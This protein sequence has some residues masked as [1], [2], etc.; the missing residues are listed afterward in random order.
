VFNEDTGIKETIFDLIKYAEK[1]DWEVIV[2]NDGSTDNTGKILKKMNRIKVINH[3]YNKGYGA[4]LK[5]GLR[6]ANTEFVAFYDGDGQHSPEDLK[7]LVENFG[8]FDMIVGERIKG[9]HREWIRR[10]GK[11]ILS[12]AANFLSGKK[13]PDLNSGMRVIKR[14]IISKLLHLMPDGFS[15]STTATIAFLNLG[16]N[17]GYYPIQT[18][19]R[20]GKSSV[21]QIKH[22]SNI[23]LLVI[24][25]VVLFNP[26]KIFLPMS[27][28]LFVFGVIYEIL[29]GIIFFSPGV[30]L[31][32][33]AL[34]MLIS[35]VII[36]FFGLVV[37]QIS[38][39]RKYI[40]F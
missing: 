3:P 28:F 11:W 5:T 6:N 36:F 12:K 26:L 9:S 38:E 32:P 4:A 39:M 34:F 21:K 24:R 23:I 1:N 15:F 8:N 20:V 37:D 22:G 33:A 7:K 27:L 40:N 18:S 14:E 29:Y 30:R 16:F 10:P 2:V 17:V 25:L 35:S 19:K 13:I 31:I